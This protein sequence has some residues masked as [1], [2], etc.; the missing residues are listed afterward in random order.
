M[1]NLSAKMIELSSGVYV[2]PGNTNV[3]VITSKKDNNTEI[4]L[5]DSG[6]TEIDGEF[7]LDVL[8]AFFEEQKE[9]FTIKAI[10][11]T[12]CHADHCG[13]HNFIKENTKCEIWATFNERAS[14]ETPIIQ[15][16]FLW[17]GY[18]PHELRTVFFM[19][20]PTFVDKIISEKDTV[21]LSD[22]RKISFVELK[23]HSYSSICVI[24]SDDLDNNVIFAGDS[25][26]P[27]SEIAKYW[28]P[29]IINP[30]EFM[31]S[32]DKLAEI[33]NL[34][35]CIPSHGDF[36]KRN[37]AE[38]IELD[39]IAI[40]STRMCIIEALDCHDKMTAEEI[41][42]YVADKNG[43]DM[44][45]SQYTLISATVKSYIAV[46]HDAK[47]IRLKIEDNKLYFSKYTA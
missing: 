33:K 6:C 13:G 25:I 12:H 44:P 40:L 39:K 19:P 18:P 22:N 35:W 43:L 38:T 41:I 30:V 15:S 34:E 31:E 26:F 24:A 37:L 14:M 4:Y 8:K 47:E 10:I 27:R 11:S 3:G 17:G 32:L 29:L 1:D 5:V 42:K 45:L 7:V 20:S 21:E 36:I 28:I 46:M 23:G 16:E 2:I 9:T